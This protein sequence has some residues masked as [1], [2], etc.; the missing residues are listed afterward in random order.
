MTTKPYY[1][2]QTLKFITKSPIHVR[3]EEY[4]TIP[5]FL[6]GGKNKIGT[7]HLSDWL[8]KD[9]NILCLNPSFYS[10]DNDTI[11]FRFKNLNK[12]DEHLYSKLFDQPN[13]I[14]INTYACIGIVSWTNFVE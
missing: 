5:C 1:F 12:P 13:T 9:Y 4:F 10:S 14:F 7:L 2:E 3:P 8:T 11:L 6:G